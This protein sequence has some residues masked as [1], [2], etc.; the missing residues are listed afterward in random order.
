MRKMK[1]AIAFIVV[2]MM[3]SVAGSAEDAARLRW[4]VDAAEETEVDRSLGERLYDEAC[5]W[6]ED[7]FSPDGRSIHPRLTVHVGQA[8]PDPSITGACL[9]PAASELY[10]PKWDSGSASAIIH[11]TI[12]TG[13]LQLM[14]QQDLNKIVKGMLAEES[15]NF[16][17][18]RPA[19]HRRANE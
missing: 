3:C 10:L 15:R 7:R 5:R 1:S 18:A 8:C 2:G 9:S 16:V 17:S 19:A 14:E 6:V 12:V 4:V 11:A 13:M